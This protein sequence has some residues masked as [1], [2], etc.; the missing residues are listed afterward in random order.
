MRVILHVDLDAF[1][2]SVEVQE[3]GSDKMV[4]L[5]KDM[6]G[7]SALLVMARMPASNF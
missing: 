7:F 5:I 6:A 1:F 3:R 4:P 2:P